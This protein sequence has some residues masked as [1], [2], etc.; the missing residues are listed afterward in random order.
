MCCIDMNLYSSGAGRSPLLPLSF[1][2]SLSL[3]R[4]RVA[5]SSSSLSLSL[6]FL[7]LSIHTYRSTDPSLF[8]FRKRPCKNTSSPP[9]FLSLAASPL[10]LPP[11]GIFLSAACRSLKADRSLSRVKI[12][13]RKFR[14]NLV[15]FEIIGR[16]RSVATSRFVYEKREKR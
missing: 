3:P 11:R 6:F 5:A 4:V 10:L 2:L 13:R 7:P 16:D 15:S 12:L 8:F 1:S 14:N 9:L